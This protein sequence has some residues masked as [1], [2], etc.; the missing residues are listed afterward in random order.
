MRKAGLPLPLKFITA[1]SV[2]KGKPDPEPYCMGAALLGVAAAD[3]VVV[4]DAPSGVGAGKAA[5]MRVLGLLT[6][7]AAEELTDADWLVGSLA[8]VLYERDGGEDLVL[9]FVP[10]R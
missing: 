5:G 3:C 9:K 10:A 4:E 6:S 8:D 7:H 2:V 1:E